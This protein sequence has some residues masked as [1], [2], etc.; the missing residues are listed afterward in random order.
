M[1]DSNDIDFVELSRIS[2]CFNLP[3][4][5]NPEDYKLSV[6]AQISYTSDITLILD[7]KIPIIN[8]MVINHSSSEFSENDFYFWLTLFLLEKIGELDEITQRELFFQILID[9]FD[10]FR[11]V[12]YINH[13][14]NLY[15]ANI[16]E[17]I[18]AI[19]IIVKKI[20]DS[21]PEFI[22]ENF[23]YSENCLLDFF[24]VYYNLQRQ[25]NKLET[26][27]R[28]KTEQPPNV[29][30]EIY[31]M[32]WKALTKENGLS[33]NGYSIETLRALLNLE[34]FETEETD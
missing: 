7:S 10:G 22:H 29:Y 2:S 9:L 19:E 8:Q 6:L 15:F 20:S 30:Y 25:I 24:N 11:E 13:K 12:H 34:S 33:D 14:S 26:N 21:S 27:S 1:Y 31:Q 17:T 18:S 28:F 32:F 16:Y 23:Q 4:L 5:K 3:T